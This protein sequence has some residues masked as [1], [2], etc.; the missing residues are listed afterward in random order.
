MNFFPELKLGEIIGDARRPREMFIQITDAYLN[1]NISFST[2]GKIDAEKG[3]YNARVNAYIKT[4]RS[5]LR[6]VD[7]DYSANQQSNQYFLETKAASQASSDKY[8]L[9]RSLLKSGLISYSATLATKIQF[10]YRE[11]LTSH[12]KLK[13]ALSLVRL[14]QDLGAGYIHANTQKSTM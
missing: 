6:E 8:K 4:V 13:L 2:L 9:Q 5:V 12:A 11:L 3:A 14:Y 7:N 10:E 1:P